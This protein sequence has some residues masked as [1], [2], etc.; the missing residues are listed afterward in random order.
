MVGH[1]IPRLSKTWVRNDIFSPSFTGLEKST[2]AFPKLSQSL[3]ARTDSDVAQTDLNADTGLRRF[4]AP[5]STGRL[6]AVDENAHGATQTV[7]VLLG[8]LYQQLQAATHQVFGC[9]RE[10][11][12]CSQ[13]VR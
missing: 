11:R 7:D 4:D 8:A 6:Q 9:H 2:S 13:H 5:F 12:Q 3:K 10:Q 1:E